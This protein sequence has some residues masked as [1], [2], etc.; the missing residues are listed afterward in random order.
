MCIPDEMITGKYM[1]H[2]NI[3]LYELDK[4]GSFR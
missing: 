4:D 3:I 2:K 1:L